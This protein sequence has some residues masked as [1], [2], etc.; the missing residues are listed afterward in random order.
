M[1]RLLLYGNGRGMKE[2]LFNKADVVFLIAL[3]VIIG[4][5]FFFVY[6]RKQVSGS[7]AEIRVDGKVYGSYPLNI[8][9]EIR[10]PEKKPENII[11]IKGNSVRMIYATCPDKSCVREGKKS[12][13][14]ETIACL[15]HKIVITV[16]SG[17]KQDFDSIAR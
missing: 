7:S 1:Q 2:P 10:I 17:T 5:S 8:D 15:P 4:A 9:R 6:F 3:T 11:E 16:R 14:G 13:N 12:K